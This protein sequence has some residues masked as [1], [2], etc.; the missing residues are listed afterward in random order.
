[1]NTTRSEVKS[2]EHAA[3][4]ASA[5]QSGMIL[6]VREQSRLHVPAF[7]YWDCNEPLQSSSLNR[8]KKNGYVVSIGNYIYVEIQNKTPEEVR[9][10]SFGT[11]GLL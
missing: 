2:T 3:I 6:I 10:V 11:L 5:S 7:G 8:S 9:R 1:M 4:P